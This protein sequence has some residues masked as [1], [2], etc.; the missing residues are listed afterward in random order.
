MPAKLSELLEV[1]EEKFPE[2]E[3]VLAAVDQYDIEFGE[4]DMDEEEMPMDM[5]MDMDEM[6]MD[7][8]APMDLESMLSEDM[9]GEE[10]DLDLDLDIEMPPRKKKKKY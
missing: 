5:E 7:E 10:E 1:L 4:D 2:D 9:E 8:E 6:P 3:D